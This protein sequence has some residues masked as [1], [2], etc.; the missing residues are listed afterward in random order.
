MTHINIL[1][2]LY[3]EKSGNVTL[4]RREIYIINDFLIKTFININIMKFKTIVFD[5][6]KNLVIIKS[7][8]SFQILIFMIIKGFKI[9]VVI[10]NKA[11][12]VVLTHFFLIVFIEHVDLL[13]NK[14]LIFESK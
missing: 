2:F 5:I 1:L 12:Y 6:N 13:I 3:S 7:Y 4:I 9:N 8:N 10:V 11:R 14:N